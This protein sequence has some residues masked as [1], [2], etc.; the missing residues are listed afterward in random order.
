MEWLNEKELAEANE[1]LKGYEI[2]IA[3]ALNP[4]EVL[5]TE[6]RVLCFLPVLSPA[7]WWGF[8]VTTKSKKSYNSIL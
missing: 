5:R 1:R 3:K 2:A 4:I 7:F 8:F 6:L